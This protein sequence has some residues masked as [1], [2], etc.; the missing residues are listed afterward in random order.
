MNVFKMHV[1]MPHVQICWEV[2]GAVVKLVIFI[3][4]VLVV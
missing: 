1:E 2:I 3:E 4:K